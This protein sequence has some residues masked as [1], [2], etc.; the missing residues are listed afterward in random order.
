M[1]VNKIAKKFCLERMRGDCSLNINAL[2]M[3][4]LHDKTGMIKKAKYMKDNIYGERPKNS[5]KKL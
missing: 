2:M 5:A 1:V 4:A 3:K